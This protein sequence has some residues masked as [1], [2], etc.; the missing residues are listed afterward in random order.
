MRKSWAW[1]SA[2]I[3]SSPP[4]KYSR[5]GESGW[6]QGVALDYI[7]NVAAEHAGELFTLQLSL[8]RNNMLSWLSWA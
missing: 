5:G 8:N 7:Q 1:D 6:S 2:L 3:K 4:G